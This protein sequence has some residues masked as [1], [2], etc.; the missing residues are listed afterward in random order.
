MKIKRHTEWNIEINIYDPKKLEKLGP[1]QAIAIAD[2]MNELSKRL[3]EAEFLLSC[4]END[5]HIPN[6]IK[7]TYK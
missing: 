7:D 2:H 3:A 4:H 5:Q 6:E 1:G